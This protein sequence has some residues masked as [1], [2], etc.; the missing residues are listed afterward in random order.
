MP[1]RKR[2]PPAAVE[3]TLAELSDHLPDGARLEFDDTPILSRPEPVEGADAK[4]TRETLAAI[5]R[6]P[7]EMLADE[8]API[9]APTAY[10]ASWWPYT[11]VLP[12]G[13]RIS[14]AKVFA[15][16]EGLYVYTRVPADHTTPDYYFP[17]LYDKTPQPAADYAARQKGVRIETPDGTIR[18]AHAGGCGCG[19]KLKP[20]R[21]TWASRIEP[22]S[23]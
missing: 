9:P 20:W 1:P 4:A 12:D 18:M 7:P 19:H 3:A 17:I 2:K 6:V 11:V 23:A 14:P 15:T 21:P 10:R 8:P 13:T 16:R 22:W 5:L